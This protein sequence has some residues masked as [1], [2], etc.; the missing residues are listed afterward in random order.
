M[1]GHLAEND[2]RLIEDLRLILYR[3]KVIAEP[4]EFA[5]ERPII[6][7]PYPTAKRRYRTIVDPVI[8]SAF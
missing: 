4:F 1:K 5:A 2:Q 7:A 8:P 3:G 6:A